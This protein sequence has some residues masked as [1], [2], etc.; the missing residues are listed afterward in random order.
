MQS[1]KICHIVAA[2]V[3]VLGLLTVIGGVLLIVLGDD[4]IAAAVKKVLFFSS[5]LTE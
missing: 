1:R 3:S 2:I 5:V 4:W